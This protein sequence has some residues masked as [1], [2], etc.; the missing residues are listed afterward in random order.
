MSQFKLSIL[1]IK[2]VVLLVKTLLQSILINIP[3]PP[4]QGRGGD[5]AGGSS[6]PAKF[7]VNEPFFW[8]GLEVPFL[9]EV[10]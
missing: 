7:F 6:A 3:G 2:D 8:R 9:K 1:L 5:G 10:I 4:E